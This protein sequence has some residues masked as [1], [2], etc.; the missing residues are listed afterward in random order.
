[1]YE[2]GTCISDPYH[3]SKDTKS[4]PSLKNHPTMRSFIFI[5]L[6]LT[7]AVQLS[8]Q[9]PHHRRGVEERRRRHGVEDRHRRRGVEEAEEERRRRRG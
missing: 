7:I 5:A 4:Y 8:E 3:I 1:M 2:G 9:N 6:A